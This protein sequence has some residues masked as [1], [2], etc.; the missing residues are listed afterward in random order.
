[1]KCYSLVIDPKLVKEIDNLIKEH[2]LF[3]SR[4][5]FIRD[6]IRARLIE[7]RKSIL[8]KGELDLGEKGLGAKGRGKQS[9]EKEEQ[10]G[11]AVEEAME[12]IEEYKF[13]GV[14]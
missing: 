2:G 3:S 7:V 10:E 13:G 6:A 5:D 11:K 1:M 14:H 9:R 12:E 4:S 8:G